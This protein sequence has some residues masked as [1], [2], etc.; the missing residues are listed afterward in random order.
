MLVV[1][2]ILLPCNIHYCAPS[3]LALLQMT[4]LLLVPTAMNLGLRLRNISFMFTITY[5]KLTVTELIPLMSS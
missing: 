2:L 4:I 1:K 3:F 5:L